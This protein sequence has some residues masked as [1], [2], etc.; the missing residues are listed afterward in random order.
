[1]GIRFG[2]TQY[3]VESQR[4]PFHGALTFKHPD[5]CG[6]GQQLRIAVHQAVVQLLE[7]IGGQEV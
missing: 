1:M 6:P 5:G 7:L 3:P 2:A 4:N